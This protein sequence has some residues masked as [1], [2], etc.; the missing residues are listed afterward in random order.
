M[1]F[2]LVAGAIAAVD[3]FGDP[4]ISV[5]IPIAYALFLH[6]PSAMAAAG[7]V[8]VPGAAIVTTGIIA[9]PVAITVTVTGTIPGCPVAIAMPVTADGDIKSR[10]RICCACDCSGG[11]GGRRNSGKKHFFDHEN[12]PEV[13]GSCLMSALM[14]IVLSLRT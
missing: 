14:V 1:N 7:P 6:L 10:I 11:D 8:V 13:L 5:I 9:A 4:A 2:G 3:F 12:L